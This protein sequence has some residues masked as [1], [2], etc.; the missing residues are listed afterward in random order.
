[1]AGNGGWC[2]E[3]KGNEENGDFPEYRRR[4]TYR[5]GYFH[6]LRIFVVRNSRLQKIGVATGIHTGE[7]VEITAGL[8]GNEQVVNNFTAALITGEQVRTA[9][10]PNSEADY[11]ASAKQ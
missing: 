4:K 7:Y 5:P 10:I 11:T 6:V 8:T 3:A 1:V 2:L 9:M